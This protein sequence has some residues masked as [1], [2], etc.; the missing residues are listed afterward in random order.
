M[1]TMLE[2]KS[3]SDE[4]GPGSQSSLRQANEARVLEALR[5]GASTQA[6]LA[7]RTALAPSTVSG[8]V[9]DLAQAGI[10]RVEEEH[11]GRRGRLV[12]LDVE[13]RVLV[14]LDVGHAHV[15]VGLASLS[16]ELLGMRHLTLTTPHACDHVL[17]QASA[18]LDD[19]LAE[20]GL[21]RSALLAGGLSIPAP[22]DLNG[23][24]VGSRAILPGWAG[25]D[26]AARAEEACGTSFSVD[27][28]ANAGALAERR[29]GAAAGADNVVYLKLGHGVGAGLILNGDL[30][31]GAT[32]V[33]GEIGH[34]IVDERGDFC[35]CGNR[36]CL[37][38]TTNA[39]HLL[40]LL[41]ATRPHIDS[42]DKLIRAAHEGDSACIRLLDDTGR[43]V[44]IAAANL[45]NLINP[46]VLVVG[47]ALA[48][49]GD[50]LLAPMRDV[51]IR[52]GVPSAVKHL[53]VRASELGARTHLMGALSIAMWSVGPA[54]SLSSA[55]AR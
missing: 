34:T 17:G 27:N 1:A 37:E 2:P 14:G 30:F 7:R 33:S 9:H 53:S 19:L 43:A 54:S 35:R 18:M 55:F 42:V 21:T 5:S 11:G 52:Y 44:G 32:G 26:L 3:G 15:S 25:I 22:L 29:W 47:G 16:Q 12:E 36:G 50:L 4:P 23:R 13:G 49:A 31:R 28:D 45:C 41:H 20:Q 46:E 6:E 24:I 8:I 10:V 38:T 48:E 39:S 51:L 40:R